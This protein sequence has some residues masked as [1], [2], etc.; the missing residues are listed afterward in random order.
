MAEHSDLSLS[1]EANQVAAP[2]SRDEGE[3]YGR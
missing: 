2:S 1:R 3:E